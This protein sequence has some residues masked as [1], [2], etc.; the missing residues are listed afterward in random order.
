MVLHDITQSRYGCCCWWCCCWC[1]Q[2]CCCC[3]LDYWCL[4]QRHCCYRLDCRHF[5][6]TESNSVLF[7]FQCRR[8]EGKYW[9]C[10]K[11]KDL[12]R[13]CPNENWKN[14]KRKEKKRKE[15]WKKKERKMKKE[16]RK[17][18]KKEKHQK[19]TS[20]R[21]KCRQE[22]LRNNKCYILVQSKSNVC[23]PSPAVP[24]TFHSTR[25]IASTT[26]AS[27]RK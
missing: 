1:F 14:E 4:L 3:C 20:N 11:Y 27:E 21:F 17:K 23:P 18:K 6:R 16:K 26:S 9:Q 13:W 2:C 12:S 19:I 5:C 8:S 10:N 25:S 7:A 22:K 15:K 24:R